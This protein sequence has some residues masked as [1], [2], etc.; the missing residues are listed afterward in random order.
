M[1]AT[2]LP[3][4]PDWQ[5]AAGRLD[6]KN[7][8]GELVGPCPSC[9][10]TDRFHVKQGGDGG[11][12]VGC[13]GCIDNGGD[14][15]GAVLKAAG[16]ADDRSRRSN[17][18]AGAPRTATPPKDRPLLAEPPKGDKRYV[19][20]NAARNP[21]F[22][23][24][25]HEATKKRGK[26]FVPY[27]R[28]PEG[29]RKGLA[30]DPRPLYR[31]PEL[32]DAPPDKQVMIVEGEK[33]VESV[34]RFSKKAV[35]TTFASGITSWKKTDWTPLHGRP[36]LLVADA[37]TPG[38][39]GMRALAAHLEPH[40]P[41][42][43]LVLPPLTPEGE[44]AV[45]IADIIETQ[46]RK[47]VPAWLKT[48]STRYAAPAEAAKTDEKKKKPAAKTAKSSEGGEPR[49]VVEMASTMRDSLLGRHEYD[50]HRGWFHVLDNGL[51][52]RDPHG[53]TLGAIVHGALE[54]ALVSGDVSRK[55]RS[56]Q[57]VTDLRPLL[58]VQGRFDTDPETIACRTGVLVDLKNGRTRQAEPA[59]RVRRSVPVDAPDFSAE[60]K[61]FVAAI[62]RVAPDETHLRWLQRF[63]GYCLTGHV[64]EHKFLFL[65]GP[66]GGGKSTIL[67][68]LRA[69]AGG[70]HRSIP[71][72]A[73]TSKYAPHPE[74]LAR[75]E[76]TRLITVPELPNG[77]WRAPTLNAFVAGDVQTARYMAKDSFDYNPVAKLIVG[78][79]NKPRIPE[80]NSGFARRLVLIPVDRVP[81]GAKD[82]HFN[83]R[84][85][86]ER[87]RILGWLVHGA[88]DYLE[89]GLGAV[90]DA[91][92]GAGEEYIAAEDRFAAWWEACIVPSSGSFTTNK[93]LLASWNAY[94]GTHHKVVTPIA[95]WVKAMQPAGVEVARMR[96]PGEAHPQRGLLGCR[97]AS[98]P[99]RHAPPPDDFYP[100]QG[101]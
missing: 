60:P 53:M 37:D 90:P 28:E 15:F 47:A 50:P 24:V 46:D 6:L 80:S 35:V 89:H 97:I 86:A 84:L 61:A 14:G 57:V 7:K 74:W 79:N 85:A 48:H 23:V 82:E 100:D 92:K 76:D 32:L 34:R 3:S 16:F 70:Y 63:L 95:E 4:W 81:E 72:D 22:V 59:D 88:M 27:T 12:L 69:I 56:G 83:D 30:V 62:E 87:P 36:L 5:D 19:Y 11:A 73:F 18:A 96:P 58:P 13:R 78:G 8:S 51:W 101:P 38:H 99:S 42:I 43:H 41:S 44:K 55:V 26:L 1:G 64:R 10:G 29:W 33:C 45:D 71:Q 75:L 68:C 25:R 77:A 67:E 52:R 39:D 66:G 40:C 65:Q 9:G 94:A 54:T 2:P 98:E 49:N 20:R 17:G 31:L 91:W 21:V 93:A